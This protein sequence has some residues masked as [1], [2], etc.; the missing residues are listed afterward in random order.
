[1]EQ[2]AQISVTDDNLKCLDRLKE[3]GYI[4]ELQEG[5]RLGAVVALNK[6]L[7]LNI[8][9]STVGTKLNTRWGTDLVDP[10]S[11]FRDIIKHLDL[12]PTNYGL[13]LR[14]LIILGLDYIY[15]RIKDEDI[16]LLGDIIND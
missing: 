4:D 1:M 6:K 12:C 5:A 9:L 10:G 3:Y 14:S 15:K 16:L 13:G 8:D 2:L 11:Y 7:Y